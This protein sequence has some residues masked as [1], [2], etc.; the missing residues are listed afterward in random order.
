MCNPHNHIL[1]STIKTLEYILNAKCLQNGI[2]FKYKMSSEYCNIFV[3]KW[4]LN[5]SS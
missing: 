2:Y 3:L 1:H 4:L 5:G